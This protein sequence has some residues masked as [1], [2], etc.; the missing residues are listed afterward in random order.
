MSEGKLFGT[1]GLKEYSGSHVL[2]TE[3]TNM[4]RIHWR[5]DMDKSREIVQRPTVIISRQ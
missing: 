3:W 4:L 1:N 2:Y 5:V